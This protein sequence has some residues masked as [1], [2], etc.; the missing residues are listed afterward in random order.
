[1]SVKLMAS[2]EFYDAELG[3]QFRDWLTEH[4]KRYKDVSNVSYSAGC[5][6]VGIEYLIDLL[7]EAATEGRYPWQQL[8]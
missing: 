6:A 3:K 8:K 5:K 7:D 4:K 1:M 2:I